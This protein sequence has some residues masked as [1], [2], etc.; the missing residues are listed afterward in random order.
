M[1][2]E[3]IIKKA[4][5]GSSEAF[6]DIY[7]ETV[8]TAYY[9]AK[10]ILL[11]E[12][13]TEDVL[14]EAYIAVFKNLANYQAG[15]LQGWVDTIV[16][17]RAKNYLR[18]KN[19]ILFSE[20]ET[21]DNP[22]VEFEEEKIEFRP[23]EKVDYSETQRLILEIVD[24]LSPEQRLSVMLFYFEDKS[25]KEIAEICECSEN[26]VKSRLNYA[27]KK[28]KEDVLELEKRGTKL[29]SISVLPFIVWTLS[30]EAKACEM[31]QG[32]ATKILNTVGGKTSLAIG[33]KAGIGTKVGIGVKT[34]ISTKVGI[35]AAIAVAVAGIAVGVIAL[36]DNKD[37]KSNEVTSGYREDIV[38]DT[39]TDD[40]EKDETATDDKNEE[41]TEQ[42][43]SELDKYPSIFDQTFKGYFQVGS[44]HIFTTNDQ[45]GYGMKANTLV[46]IVNEQGDYIVLTNQDEYGEKLYKSM[47]CLN[48]SGFL[49]G[50]VKPDDTYV[51]V[52]YYGNI[53]GANK[54]YTELNFVTVNGD[55]GV[56]ASSDKNGEAMYDI[57]DATCKLVVENCKELKD[58]VSCDIV[59]SYTYVY[60][61]I[62]DKVE[63][64]FVYNDK[65]ECIDN[66]EDKGTYR[67][68]L[69]NSYIWDGT[70]LRDGNRQ[71]VEIPLAEEVTSHNDVELLNVYSKNDE[72]ATVQ[73]EA[74][75]KK[76]EYS[77]DKSLKV[78]T[79]VNNPAYIEV[80][81]FGE[82]LKLKDGLDGEEFIAFATDEKP[83]FKVDDWIG[84]MEKVVERNIT[85]NYVDA[86]MCSD[87]VMLVDANVTYGSEKNG[88]ETVS[89]AFFLYE[90]D[91][92]NVNKA[93]EIGICNDL[94]EKNGIWC[95]T[96][97]A[98][99]IK[100]GESF[101]RRY[102]YYAG[103]GVYYC[104]FYEDSTYTLFSANGEE[105]CL[106]KNS[107]KGV[108]NK[109]LC[110]EVIN[111]DG[112]RYRLMKTK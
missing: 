3:D 2:T 51:L 35:A 93:V 44:T 16:A 99:M 105:I 50:L 32:M 77:I 13:A 40:S 62:D 109:D 58:V 43:T 59:G 37:N 112:I 10:R 88:W 70:S 106:S 67:S 96:K 31:P 92:Y 47:I 111:S 107:I 89:Y 23:D 102:L 7:N 46:Y 36:G 74:G 75:G 80:E 69:N 110:V 15:N 22:V 41:T 103:D 72:L 94:K 60:G 82:V 45:Y 14:Q 38:A 12:D 53:Y 78:R 29:Y 27:R 17:N 68:I 4:Q 28:I 21:E 33:T 30:K 25:I 66:I 11:D 24:N 90:K 52:D 101:F 42:E 85:L 48:Q 91:G 71:I 19:P 6:A 65:S 95:S 63:A 76:Y 79:D 54:G 61:N 49:M 98:L 39:L 81:S 83:L 20:M 56:I 87:G 64:V 9:V 8:R 100:D 104:E 108:I 34:I 18:T 1:I 86:Y 26:T 97:L 5:A 57:Y 55:V 84:V 73:C